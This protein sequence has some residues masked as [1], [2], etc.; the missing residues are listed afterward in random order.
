[1]LQLSTHG[2]LCRY[3][4]SHIFS[5]SVGKDLYQTEFLRLLLFVVVD[6]MYGWF[7]ITCLDLVDQIFIIAY[8]IDLILQVVDISARWRLL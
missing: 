8:A 2:S 5:K 3:I 7:I 4:C 6:P 1:M